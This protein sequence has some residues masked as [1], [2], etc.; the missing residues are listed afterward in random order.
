MGLTW[1]SSESRQ[2]TGP[3]RLWVR[4]RHPRGTFQVSYSFLYAYVLLVFPVMPLS[5]PPCAVQISSGS[6]LPYADLGADQY[7][8]AKQN[9]E[10]ICNKSLSKA[11]DLLCR[12]HVILWTS[13]RAYQLQGGHVWNAGC[14]WRRTRIQA[15]CLYPGRMIN[16]NKGRCGYLC[17]HLPCTPTRTRI[18]FNLRA[19]VV[20]ALIYA[21]GMHALMPQED[22]LHHCIFDNAVTQ[23]IDLRW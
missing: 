3:L 13:P 15:A 23:L 21:L 11:S 8:Q 14:P 6:A 2:E 5:K 22:N 7:A 1:I 10:L 17:Q 12:D 18:Y 9:A 4:S 16:N 19:W 20:K